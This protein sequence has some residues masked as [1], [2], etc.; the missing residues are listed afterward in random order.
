MGAPLPPPARRFRPDI[1]GLRA[2]AVAVVVLYHLGVPGFE[3]GYV[4]VDVFF[5][6]SGY[7]ITGLLTAEIEDRGHVRLSEFYARRIRRLL[8]ASALVLI[9]TVLAGTIA[10]PAL[11]LAELRRS[12]VATALFAANI[13]LAI[14]G[15]DYLAGGAEPP[16]Q[17][18]WSLAVEEQF[19]LVWPVLLT[20]VAAHTRR[21]GGDIVRSL[22][23]VVGAVTV[24]SLVAS[25][26]VTQ[27]VQ[28]WAFFLL[29]TRA[30]ELAAGGLLALVVRRRSGTAP[31]R[32]GAL[33]IAGL[34]ILIVTVMT[35]DATTPF[36]SAYAAVPVIGTLAVL[37]AGLRD[38]RL[39][40]LLS[41]RPFQEVGRR[42]Y[43]IYLWHWPL[44][45]YADAVP[46]GDATTLERAL[47][48]AATLG[49]SWISFAAVEDPVR[50]NDFL[51]HRRLA[52]Y[53]AGVAVTSLSLVAVVAVTSTADLSGEG[54]AGVAADASLEELFA[55]PVA[56]VPND[57]SPP[58]ADVRD[59]KPATYSDGCHRDFLDTDVDGCVYG[60]PAGDTEIVLFGD[61]HAAQW[62]PAAEAVAS[63]RGWRL[64]SLT[65]SGCPAFEV[66]IVNSAL[67]R[68]YHEC[69]TWRDA[70]IDRI[71]RE[72]P[73]VVLLA[74]R[75]A[76]DWRDRQEKGF[77]TG[78]TRTLE[79]LPDEVP[80]LVLGETPLIAN[81][82]PACLSEHLTD[83]DAC[84]ADRGTALPEGQLRLERESTERGGGRYVEA[85]SWVC[86]Q[87]RCPV[88]AGDVLVYR[89]DDHLTT[90]F[91]RRLAPRLAEAITSV[92]AGEPR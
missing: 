50:R 43:A 58:L 23:V 22:L 74:S 14:S 2:L 31:S 64:I 45:V 44:A 37:F 11:E 85:G 5:V 33:G 55:E 1:E 57:L 63:E 27:R 76:G 59:D 18:Y 60:D 62:F 73:D 54:T 56:A 26:V 12:A 70:T 78:L 30:W 47:V 15:T 49:L 3:G 90:E 89:D 9:A 6:L 28:P 52:T 17:H 84:A 41:S 24:L 86:P 82:P 40:G 72:R 46:G 42:S 25:V 77:F 67:G 36:P 20:I 75:T 39:Q 13:D 65:K 81:D 10:L 87:E 92:L 38:G 83:V 68:T 69:D 29:P 7:L 91:A 16:L 35:F 32:S 48:L 21:R 34:V 8:P 66:T 79:R 61:S 88:V 80:T 53:G 19:Y 4:G 71:H 51:R